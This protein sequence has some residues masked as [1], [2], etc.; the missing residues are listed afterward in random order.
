MSED[1]DSQMNDAIKAISTGF[2]KMSSGVKDAQETL[3]MTLLRNEQRMSTADRKNYRAA[4]ELK[5]R[6]E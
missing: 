1:I 6:I 3:S 4:V 5:T 2:S